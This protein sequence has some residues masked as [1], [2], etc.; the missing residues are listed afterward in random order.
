MYATGCTGIALHHPQLFTIIY[1]I[2]GCLS[3]EIEML[4]K[5]SGKVFHPFVNDR[6][7][8]GSGSVVNQPFRAISSVGNQAPVLRDEKIT[9]TFAMDILLHHP[10]TILC[11]LQCLTVLRGN[12]PDDVMSKT[13]KYR[14]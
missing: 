13:G 7:K 5:F 8:E 4:A 11:N 6:L 12:I 10:L 2:K 1:K 14:F 9:Q 3:R